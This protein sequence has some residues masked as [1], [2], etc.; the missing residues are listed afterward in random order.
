LCP[1]GYEKSAMVKEAIEVL[2]ANLM[3]AGID[4]ILDDRDQRLG[5]MLA[6]WELIGVPHRVV[7]G[8]RNLKEGK[9]EYQ[10]RSDAESQLIAT[11]MISDFLLERIHSEK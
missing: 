6:D 3:K 9:M 7:V 5:T 10:G 1:I 4:V 2:Y 11:D 8:E